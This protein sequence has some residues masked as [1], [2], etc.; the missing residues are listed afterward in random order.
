MF[1]HKL[2]LYFFDAV[3]RLDDYLT[4]RRND[5]IDVE[6]FKKIII[7]EGENGASF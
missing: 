5:L 2:G 3:Y 7:E 4:R 6:H 1:V